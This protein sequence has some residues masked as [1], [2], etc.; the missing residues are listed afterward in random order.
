MSRKMRDQVILRNSALCLSCGDEV[1][2]EYRH[3]F[4]AC[5]C[6]NLAVDGGRDYMKRTVADLAMHR[7]TSVVL[8]FG[9]VLQA[10]ED[11]KVLQAR[12]KDLQ[13]QYIR[14]Y[15]QVDFLEREQC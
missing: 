15:D 9:E 7:D 5:G 14:L 12:V 8:D 13:E 10:L 3:D 2:S 11:I 6:G 4:K 1:V